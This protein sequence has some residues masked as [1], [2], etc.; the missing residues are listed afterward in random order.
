M[1]ITDL[2]KKNNV[3]V[4]HPDCQVECESIITGCLLTESSLVQW[5]H[6]KKKKGECLAINSSQLIISELLMP[7]AVKAFRD[8]ENVSFVITEKDNLPHMHEASPPVL[9]FTFNGE[10]RLIGL[11]TFSYS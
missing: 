2:G 3:T 6:D 4:R 5:A 7:E 8:E 1:Q 10:E 9:I 11:I